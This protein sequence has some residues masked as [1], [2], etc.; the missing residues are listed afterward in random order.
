VAA[1]SRGGWFVEAK[2]YHANPYDGHTLK[3]SLEQ[4]NRIAGESEH[5]FVDMGYRGHNFRG[6]IQ[7]HVDKRRRGR[8]VKSLWRWM[9]RRPAIESGVGDLKREHRMD[10][11]RPK[12]VEGDRINAI[13]SAVG[14]NFWKLLKRAANFL[15]QIFL[16]LQFC[17]RTSFC[18]IPGRI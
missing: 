9:K 14:M 16:W 7:V 12:G 3:D 1:I 4:V 15:R 13:L 10:R 6:S 8:T 18:Q 2:A 5:A 11:N 17:Q